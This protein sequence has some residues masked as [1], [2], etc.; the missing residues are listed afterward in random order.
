MGLSAE[1]DTEEV[2]IDL[3]GRY[4][5]IASQPLP[6]FDTLAGP[7]FVARGVRDRRT[8]PYA[9]VSNAYGM[10][11]MEIIQLMRSVENIG[12]MRMLDAGVVSWP[13]GTRRLIIV[14]E[15][16]GGKRLMESLNDTVEPMPEEVLTRLVIQPAH[17][18]LADL[19][20]RGITHGAIRPTNMFFRDITSSGLMIGECVSSPCGYN[21]PPVFETIERAMTLPAGRGLGSAS[22][23][24]YALGVSILVLLLGRN[25][26]KHMDDET[27]LRLRIER[28]SYPAMV[29]TMRLSFTITEPLRGLLTDDPKQ[30]WSLNDLDLWLNGRRLSP[31]QPQVPKRGARP[32]EFEGEEYLYCRTLARAFGNNPTAAAI[33]IDTGDIDRWLR[34]SMSDEIRAVAVSGAIET[35]SA[36]GKGPTLADRLVSRVCTALDPPAP[37]R[38]K[39]KAVMP[40]GIGTA[41][42]EACLR[43]EGVQPLAEIITYQLPMF[44]VNVQY[45]FRPE[46][47]PLIHTFDMMRGYLEVANPGLGIERVLYELN[48]GMPCISPMLFDQFPMNPPDLIK[49]LDVA[50]RRPDRPREPIDRHVAAFLCARNRRFEE[51]LLAQIAPGIEPVRRVIAMLTIL[52]ETQRKYNA[53]PVP[54]LCEWLATL[55]KPAVDRY[56]NRPLQDRL[57]KDMDAACRDG[58]INALVHLVDDVEQVRKD[59]EGFERARREYQISL[60]EIR[61]LSR[62]IAGRAEIQ[63]NQGRQMAA[64]AAGGISIV[65]SVI[66]LVIFWAL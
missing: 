3:G 35:A 29:G 63:E 36:A 51:V 26:V 5:I 20:G 13:D 9:I 37:I 47:V 55:L 21:Q 2:V 64:Y 44:W 59:Q 27:F 39:T 18:A 57:K 16:P 61:F 52:G 58:R 22:D 49:A 43:G 38:Y 62:R 50:A 40:D 42:A 31:K 60:K 6:Y 33:A 17:T 24:L 34:R 56:R 53:E 54:H 1:K 11:R 65:L 14:C 23:D 66:I 12:L 7:A 45:D 28:G 30:R 32:F 41:L 15:R 4:E 19:A 10:A 48:Q 25:P 46:Y 8:E